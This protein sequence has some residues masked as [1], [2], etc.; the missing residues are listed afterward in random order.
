[1]IYVLLCILNDN[2][3]RKADDYFSKRG[4]LAQKHSKSYRKA[5]FYSIIIIILLKYLILNLYSKY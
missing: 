4:F 5:T 3:K 2:K 1:M